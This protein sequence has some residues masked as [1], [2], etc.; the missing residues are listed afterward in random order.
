M[1]AFG[2]H[3]CI[4]DKNL[5]RNV[6]IVRLPYVYEAAGRKLK[7]GIIM[8]KKAHKNQRKASEEI[9]KISRLYHAVESTQEPDIFR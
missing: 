6:K 1:V 2:I 5:K 7:V 3:W 9:P 4:N 8:P